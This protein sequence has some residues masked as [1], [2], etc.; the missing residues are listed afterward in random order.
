MLREVARSSVVTLLAVAAIFLPS[1]LLFGNV[2]LCLSLPFFLALLFVYCMQLTTLCVWSESSKSSLLSSSRA[3]N[4]GLLSKT[5][6]FFFP[7]QF[8][9][10]HVLITGGSKGIGLALALACVK[11]NAK[12]VSLIA[13]TQS[14]LEAAQAAC[15]QEARKH[16]CALAVQILSADL[17]DASKVQATMEEAMNLKGKVL[18]SAG[19]SM[20]DLTQASASASREVDGSVESEASLCPVDFLFCNAAAVEPKTLEASSAAKISWILDMNVKSTVLQVKAVLPAMRK[21]RFGCICFTNSIGAFVPIYGFSLYSATKAAFSAFFT[22]LEQEAAGN[23]VLFANAY[24]PSVDTPGFQREKEVRPDVTARLEGVIAVR[25]PDDVAA[26]VLDQLERG[27]NCITVCEEGWLLA[28]RAASFGYATSFA[29]LVFEVLGA[30]L[31]RLYLVWLRASFQSIAAREAQT[32]TADGHEE[33]DSKK[34][35]LSFEGALVCL[36]GSHLASVRA[37]SKVSHRRRR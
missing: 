33:Q 9:G 34:K 18:F 20:E 1:F 14:A 12:V 28:R 25:N 32:S 2:S 13:R 15:L 37:D 10:R 5:R 8:D 11:K 35:T 21:R 31:V 36:F 27:R 29:N 6:R 4:T 24:L 22:A 26:S 7:Y 23:N 30:G 17:A 16:N 19:A 3:G